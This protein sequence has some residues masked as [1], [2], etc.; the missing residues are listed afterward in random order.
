MFEM[1]FRL[2]SVFSF[3]MTVLF[4]TVLILAFAWSWDQMVRLVKHRASGS[5]STG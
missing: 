1:I 4:L 5:D 3:V 2:D